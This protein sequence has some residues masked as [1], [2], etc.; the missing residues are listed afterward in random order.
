MAL[1]YQINFTS[2]R[3]ATGRAKLY[4]A[5]FILACLLAVAGY[6]AN[7][8]WKEAKKPVLQ[9]R[10]ATSQTLSERIAE[11]LE[12]WQR[13][14]AAYQEV[15]LYVD[16]E[17]Q[18]PPWRMIDVLEGLEEAAAAK[19]TNR[20]SCRFLPAKLTVTRGEGF[21]LTGSL[22]LPE[23][24]KVEYR[25]AMGMKMNAFITNALVSSGLST[26]AVCTCALTWSKAE[27]SAEDRTLGATLRVTVTDPKPREYPKPPAELAE[28]L[29]EVAAWRDAVR[30]C[31]LAVNPARKKETQDVGTLLSA[32]V[33]NNRQLLGDRYERI[34]TLSEQALNP[35]AVTDEIGK[36]AT[37]QVP[38]DVKAFETAWRELSY[39]QWRRER[40]LD[41]PELDSINVKWGHLSEALPKKEDFAAG[42]AKVDDYLHA[43][44]N[45]VLKKHI[46][47][48]STFWDRVLEPGIRNA[49]DKALSP[50]LAKK[51][52]IDPN[53]KRVA[54]PLWAVAFG[55]N[56]GGAA[57]QAS[58]PALSL[59]DLKAVLRSMETNSA[60]TWVSSATATFDDKTEAPDGSW[61]AIR[62]VQLEGR[63]PCWLGNGEQ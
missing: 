61:G 44:T 15:R 43:F 5:L 32:L 19:S 24:D 37:A 52:E 10:L 33:A 21:T 54:F 12:A 29:K 17:G 16:H 11:T 23:Y 34:K 49:T 42:T 3:Q 14:S 18:T 8:A 27:P 4:V 55:G 39:R 9:P 60:G 46:A 56:A 63:V 20:V 28:A 26:C 2:E 31:K 25:D 40:T 45:G 51:I 58:A 62:G 13:A 35:L 30:K 59:A 50:Q 57:Q 7:E 6:Y 41:R 36:H 22:P 1:F 53:A 38:A 48:D 47:N